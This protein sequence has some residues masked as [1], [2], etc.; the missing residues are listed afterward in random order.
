LC[1][2]MSAAGV[3]VIGTKDAL[4]PVLDDWR[5]LAAARGNAF[6]TPEWYLSALA[7]YDQARPAVAVMRRDGEV[8]GVLP[9]VDFRPRNGFPVL[10]FPGTRFADLLQ[11]ADQAAT[12]EELATAAAPALARHLGRRCSLDLGR[13]DAGATWWRELARAWPSRMSVVSQPEDVLP[14]IALEGLDWDQ[15]LAT[16]SGQFRNQLKRKM[17]S[18]QRDHEINLRRSAGREEVASDIE[19][20]FELHDARWNEREGTSSIADPRVRDLHRRFAA[21]AHE[22]GWLRLYVL[23]VDGAPAAAWYGWRVGDRY[24]YYQ[25]GFDPAWSR[26]S[27]GFLLLAETIREAIEE[28][29]TEYD[30]L[31][32]DE[33]FKARFATSRRLGR[34]VLL[35]PPASRARLAASVREAAR[36]GVRAT[37]EPLR[38]RIRAFRGRLIQG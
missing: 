4:A 36:S 15:Y 2:R 31:L 32:G 38:R 6:I 16:R 29:A 22:R 10:G 20:L 23:E 37:P 24:A 26:Y 33:A 18:L 9:L 3:E 34:S 8:Q 11:P 17:R 27:I 13:V 35:A 30:L 5:G 7:L 12:D 1:G 19:T 21:A 25:A 28:G 14:Y